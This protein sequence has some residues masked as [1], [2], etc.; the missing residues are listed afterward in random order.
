MYEWC[1]SLSGHLLYLYTPGCTYRPFTVAAGHARNVTIPRPNPQPPPPAPPRPPPQ[2]TVFAV[3]V[4]ADQVVALMHP[5]ATDLHK[6][7]MPLAA[8]SALMRGTM[9]QSL[10]LLLQTCM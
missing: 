4:A 3:M 7:G 9:R 5:K 10:G 8:C 1:D 6:R 2:R